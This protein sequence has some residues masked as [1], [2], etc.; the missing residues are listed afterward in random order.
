MKY[1]LWKTISLLMDIYS[2]T[3]NTLLY[4]HKITV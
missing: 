2:D 3:A 4:H 1:E